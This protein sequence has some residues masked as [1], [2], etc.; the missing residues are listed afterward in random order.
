MT[1]ENIGHNNPPKSLEDFY[2]LSV[3]RHTIKIKIKELNLTHG[4]S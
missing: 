1:K 3:R 2:L 4:N